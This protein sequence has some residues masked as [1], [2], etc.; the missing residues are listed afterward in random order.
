VKS[1]ALILA[2]GACSGGAEDSESLKDK[3]V[4]S[5]FC[6]GVCLM[7]EAESLSESIDEEIGAPSA[8]DHEVT[9]EGDKLI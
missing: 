4:Q 6:L 1:L 5:F 8:A 3:R 2:L 9:D 7:D